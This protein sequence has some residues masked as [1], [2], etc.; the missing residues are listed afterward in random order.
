MIGICH[1]SRRQT[2]NIKKEKKRR[3]K[4]S[5]LT[6]LRKDPCLVFE[7]FCFEIFPQTFTETPD[8]RYGIGRMQ[9]IPRL[10]NYEPVHT[11]LIL[12]KAW[13]LLQAAQ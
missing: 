13:I 10:S 7:F 1:I 9:T 12:Q 4:P 2:F 3:R 6:N 11:E 8:I 5:T